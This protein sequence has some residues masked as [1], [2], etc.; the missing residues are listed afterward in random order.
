MKNL[1]KLKKK[2]QKKN[3]TKK[4]EKKLNTSKKIKKRLNKAIDTLSSGTSKQALE[5]M[6][7][8]KDRTIEAMERVFSLSTKERENAYRIIEMFERL[9]DFQNQ[10]LKYERKL[11]DAWDSV[12]ELSRGE[13]IECV[14]TVKQLKQ[15]NTDLRGEIKK[16][17]SQSQP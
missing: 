16:L 17:L 9:V 12:S 2:Q 15:E 13:R 14:E 11:E 6:L 5:G 3:K 8:E 4:T 1:K 7:K 10:S